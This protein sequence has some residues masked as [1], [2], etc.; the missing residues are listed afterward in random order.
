MVAA[1]MLMPSHDG[2]EVRQ[3]ITGSYSLPWLP[4]LQ[5]LLPL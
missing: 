2:W 1:L 4:S 3:S 5:Q